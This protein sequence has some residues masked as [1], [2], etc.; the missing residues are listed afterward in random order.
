MKRQSEDSCLSYVLDGGKKRKEEVIT[1][2]EE[3]D[4]NIKD[5]ES[6]KRIDKKKEVLKSLGNCDVMENIASYLNNQDLGSL[7]ETCQ[8][9]KN[10]IDEL[11]LWRKRALKLSEI[12]GCKRG[13]KKTF[14]YKA[15]ES[16]HYPHCL[17]FSFPTKKIVH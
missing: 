4:R 6:N 13:C 2:D 17:N 5:N 10:S 16:A 7:Y 12:S 11:S 15:E 14:D 1:L 3:E 9:L 8:T